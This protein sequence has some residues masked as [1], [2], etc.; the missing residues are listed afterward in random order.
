MAVEGVAGLGVE[1]I[2][3]LPVLTRELLQKG[4]GEERY[5]VLALPQRR[6]VDVHDVEAVEK[7]FPETP[8][9][10]FRFQ[11]PVGAATMRTSTSM[12]SSPPTASKVRSCRTRSI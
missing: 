1:A 10:Y 3:L 6:Y 7:V 5:V 4:A 11:I 8:F 12:V 2:Y 9:L